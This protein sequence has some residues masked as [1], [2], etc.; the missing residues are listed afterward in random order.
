MQLMLRHHQLSLF[1]RLKA[2]SQ[3]IESYT[4][5]THK[6]EGGIYARLTTHLQNAR[7]S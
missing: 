7:E 3:I 5:L 2:T 1:I 4:L 6:S